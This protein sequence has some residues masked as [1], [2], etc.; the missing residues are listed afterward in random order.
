M[1]YFVC[2]LILIITLI[3]SPQTFAQ[4]RSA[5]DVALR[6]NIQTSITGIDAKLNDINTTIAKIERNIGVLEKNIKDIKTQELSLKKVLS[7]DVQKHHLAMA[8]LARIERQPLRAMLTYDAF[9]IQPQRQPILAISRKALNRDIEQSRTKLRELLIVTYEAELK[10]QALTTALANMQTQREK[11]QK[12]HTE[13]KK[14]MALSPRELRKLATRSTKLGEEGNLKELLK[15]ETNLSGIIPKIR[16]PKYGTLPLKG[17]VTQDFGKKDKRTE[18]PAKGITIAGIQGQEVVA[19]RDGRILYNGKFK[20][21][22]SLIIME[23]EKSTHSLYGGITN[24]DLKTGTFITAGTQLGKL[25]ET[26]KKPSL[27]LEVRKNGK[28]VNPT[29]WLPK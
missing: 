5:Q 2:S 10:Q 4:S 15:L 19:V 17:I 26:D 20:G 14:V 7:V 3:T 1:P 27:Y 6:K 29:G 28:S 23:H 22:G 24:K 13:Q 25:S 8:N 16:K 9:A 18:L 21:F 12:L 11:L